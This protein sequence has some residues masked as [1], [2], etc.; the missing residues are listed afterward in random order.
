MGN[1]LLFYHLKASAIWHYKRVLKGAARSDRHEPPYPLRHEGAK[2]EEIFFGGIVP[3]SGVTC[4]IFQT[5]CVH[6]GM[7]QGWKGEGN[8]LFC[9]VLYLALD[10][11]AL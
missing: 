5:P 10:T 6:R 9:F 1:L 4:F 2:E 8:C 7:E 3:R 11:H